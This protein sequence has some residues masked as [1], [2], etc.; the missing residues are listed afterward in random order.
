MM[1]LVASGASFV[2]QQRRLDVSLRDDE[3]LMT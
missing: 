3:H 2:V 1:I